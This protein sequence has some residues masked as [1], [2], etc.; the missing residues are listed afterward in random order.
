M[1]AYE[2]LKEAREDFSVVT[3]SARIIAIS[4]C[5]VRCRLN[6]TSISIHIHCRGVC[7]DGELARYRCN[8]FEEQ[9]TPT[10]FTRMDS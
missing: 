7:A 5:K 9:F 8:D 4:F 3:L 1:A 10:V 6:S 2:N